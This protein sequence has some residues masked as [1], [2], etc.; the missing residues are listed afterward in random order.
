M[1][2]EKQQEKKEECGLN[3]WL[4]KMPLSRQSQVANGAPSNA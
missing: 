4:I 2:G 3:W 1:S